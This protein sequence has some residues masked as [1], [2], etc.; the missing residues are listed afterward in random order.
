[1][2]LEPTVST[3]KKPI[4]TP[5]FHYDIKIKKQDLSQ[6]NKE[7]LKLIDEATDKTVCLFFCRLSEEVFDKLVE[8][9]K[10]LSFVDTFSKENL[11]MVKKFEENSKVIVF[12]TQMTYEQYGEYCHHIKMI[13]EQ[14]QKNSQ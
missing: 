3:F 12:L 13:T 4:L 5:D 7:T 6:L 2:S 1:M 9:C 10:I 11:I 8:K 14:A